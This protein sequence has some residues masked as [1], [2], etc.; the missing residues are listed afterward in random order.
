VY[1]GDEAVIPVEQFSLS[2][3]RMRTVRQAVHRLQRHGYSSATVA[4]GE[5]GPALRAELTTVEQA[6][7][8]GG[9]RKGFT[10]EMDSLFLLGGHDAM[11]VIGRDSQGR[12]AGFLH[13]AVSPH[14]RSLSLSTMPRLP[15]TP[16][17]FNAWLI[18]EA[19]GWARRHRITQLSL[20]FAPFAGLLTS[21]ADLPTWQRVQR[22]A[23]LRL[24]SLL[25]LQLDNLHRF[26]AQFDPAWLPRHV[27]VQAWAD[28]PR[29][30]VTAM[31]AEGYLPRAS[32]IRGRAWS[33]G[34]GPVPAAQTP[35]A[36]EPVRDLPLVHPESRS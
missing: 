20:N 26:N 6:W 12:I 28:L 33:P 22:R 18:T 14:S 29:V 17:G 24:K 36:G 34:P 15:G 2:G 13:L 4:A 8:P 10:M 19:I 11:F 32:L 9:T 16:N 3:R 30:A 23:L 7:L 21:H 27:V 1:H 35:G 25:A 31:A 5:L